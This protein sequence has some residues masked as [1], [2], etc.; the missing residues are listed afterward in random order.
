MG[1]ALVL[2]VCTKLVLKL[3]NRYLYSRKL[4]G[5]NVEGVISHVV[6]KEF[7]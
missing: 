7:S 3:K 6:A 4:V 2:I 5:F 1:L